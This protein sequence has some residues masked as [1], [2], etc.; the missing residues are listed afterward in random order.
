M[1]SIHLHHLQFF[2]Y[3]GLYENE[4]NNGNNFEMDVDIDLDTDEKITSLSQTLDYVTVHEI[5][6]KRMQQA[7]PLLETL[8]QDLADLIYEADRRVKKI[9]IMIKKVSPP[10]PDFKG[11]VGVSFKK[12]F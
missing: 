7:T 6:Y 3:H 2:A 12:E 9:S 8:A 5:I 1:L 4:K 11:T 10:I